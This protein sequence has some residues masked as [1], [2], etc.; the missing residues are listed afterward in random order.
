MVIWLSIC[1]SLAQLFLL[2]ALLTVVVHSFVA[3]SSILDCCDLVGFCVCVFSTL[4]LQL[5]NRLGF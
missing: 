4:C 1:L 2:C 3:D 5:G